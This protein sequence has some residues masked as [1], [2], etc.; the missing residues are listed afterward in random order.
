M[1]IE[2]NSYFA[3]YKYFRRLF[4]FKNIFD[5]MKRV[6]TL[7]NERIIKDYGYNDHNDRLNHEIEVLKR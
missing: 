6:K 2:K 3:D 5:L 1:A 7:E 4:S